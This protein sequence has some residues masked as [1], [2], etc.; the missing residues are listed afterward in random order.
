MDRLSAVRLTI[1][2]G[3]ATFFGTGEIARLPECVELTGRRRAFIVA[4]PGVVA[5]GAAAMV[6]SVLV[7]AGVDHTVYDRL[8]PNPDLGTLEMGGRALT[9]F[10]DCAVIGL[11]GGTALDA[12]KGI[13]LAAANELPPRQLDYRLQLAG[14]GLPVIAVPTTAGTG[15]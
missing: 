10:G 1:G 2:S 8:R 14:P 3:S 12:A 5:S 7:E 13:S 15:A 9:E 6:S 11:G 4:D